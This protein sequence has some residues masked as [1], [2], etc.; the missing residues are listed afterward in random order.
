MDYFSALLE[1]GDLFTLKQAFQGQGNAM[2]IGYDLPRL[3]CTALSTPADESSPIH[4]IL[5]W[6]GEGHS[7]FLNPNLEYKKVMSFR[8]VRVVLWIAPPSDLFIFNVDKYSNYV[9]NDRSTNLVYLFDE[10]PGLRDI[11]V[12]HV[13][14]CWLG[15]FNLLFKVDNLRTQGSQ[16]IFDQYHE[17]YGAV[18]IGF[19]AKDIGKQYKSQ[20]S[21]TSIEP[22]NGSFSQDDTG[23]VNFNL[24]PFQLHDGVRT[25]SDDVDESI[26]TE[27]V[28]ENPR[29]DP[30]LPT[31]QTQPNC[32]SGRLRVSPEPATKPRH[33]RSSYSL[34]V[35]HD[36]QASLVRYEGQDSDLDLDWAN[37][38]RYRRLAKRR[39]ER[40][41][42]S[43]RRIT[44]PRPTAK[45][46][47]YTKALL[48][49]RAKAKIQNCTSKRQKQ[50]YGKISANDNGKGAF[51]IVQGSLNKSEDWN[52]PGPSAGEDRTPE[53]DAQNPCSYT[54]SQTATPDSL[55]STEGSNKSKERISGT[56]S[57]GTPQAPRRQSPS[58]QSVR[59]ASRHRTHQWTEDQDP[60]TMVE[61]YL[62][63]VGDGTGNGTDTRTP[64][65][66]I[67][68]LANKRTR[69]LR[70]AQPVKGPLGGVSASSGLFKGMVFALSFNSEDEAAKQLTKSLIQRAS[71]KILVTGFDE[72]F[73]PACLG[74][75]LELSPSTE[76]RSLAIKSDFQATSFTAL[77]ADSHS[78]K[79]KYMQALALGF[80]CLSAKWISR[81]ISRGK[82]VDWSSYVLCAG[83]SRVLGGAIRSRNIPIYEASNKTLPETLEE[84]PAFLRN[85]FI[86]V[87]REEGSERNHMPYLILLR[88]LG[89]TV[90]GARS[91]EQVRAKIESSTHA[92]DFIYITGQDASAEQSRPITNNNYRLHGIRVLTGETLVQSIILGR[93]VEEDEMEG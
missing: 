69:S 2:L 90:V 13:E 67:P 41:A 32:R 45:S 42:A 58:D 40:A 65:S 35:D 79:A 8:N 70:S 7:L 64:R 62:P 17:T 88:M 3:D 48:A 16:P 60:I 1:P 14:D 89:A 77:I 80:P 71:G 91:L 24:E 12:T 81:C 53:T 82:V 68:K 63:P 25:S 73:E 51:G 29:D 37:T 11:K 22:D 55:L 19:P 30:M 74:L 4:L 87:V 59:A 61:S 10:A 49:D 52:T 76:T 27:S 78:R 36:P 26:E 46:Q 54:D 28:F 50:T 15:R 47:K 66:S 93:I 83:S 34:E 18:L 38:F 75:P 20:T 43:L 5:T 92:F 33:S 56:A 31:L 23:A 57:P 21:H 39:Q 9:R 85:M 86:L 72:L 84:R 44:F 6:Y